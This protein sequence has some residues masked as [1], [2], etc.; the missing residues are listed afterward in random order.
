MS[1]EVGSEKT[2][3]KLVNSTTSGLVPQPPMSAI[4]NRHLEYVITWYRLF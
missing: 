2:A 3:F 1:L 4:P